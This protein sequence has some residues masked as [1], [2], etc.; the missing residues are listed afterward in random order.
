M[1]GL[2]LVLLTSFWRM[3]WFWFYGE[4]V[5]FWETGMEFKEKNILHCL[6]EVKCQQGFTPGI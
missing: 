1:I 5:L 4:L 2:M 3:V 6:R